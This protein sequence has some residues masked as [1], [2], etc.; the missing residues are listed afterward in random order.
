MGD[1]FL[2]SDADLERGDMELMRRQED[3]TM[4]RLRK[5][6][7]VIDNDDDEI[8]VEV[9]GFEIRSWEYH[10]EHERRWKIYAARE[11][12][13]GWYRAMCGG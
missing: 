11:F 2:N 5:T 6:P 10:S 13:E 9:D 8:R 7:R 1:Q 12:V 4:E 3:E